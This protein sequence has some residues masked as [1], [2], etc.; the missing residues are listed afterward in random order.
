MP[1]IVFDAQTRQGRRSQIAL[2]APLI[3]A[4]ILAVIAR[5]LGRTGSAV[6]S[7]RSRMLLAVSSVWFVITGIA[8]ARTSLPSGRDNP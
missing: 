4:S 5:T 8:A 6:L 3:A 1:D 7:A 2:R